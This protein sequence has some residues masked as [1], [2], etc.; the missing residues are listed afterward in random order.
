MLAQYDVEQ[1]AFTRSELDIY[2]AQDHSLGVAFEQLLPHG[3][4]V[5][6]SGHGFLSFAG[7]RGFGRLAEGLGAELSATA[8]Y[9]E[10][11]ESVLFGSLG[12]TKALNS[13]YAFLGGNR[14]ELGFQ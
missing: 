5:G 9:A 13:D 2:C 10:H 7:L 14:Q 6:A 3:L 12:G 8:A 4:R 1:L 11:F